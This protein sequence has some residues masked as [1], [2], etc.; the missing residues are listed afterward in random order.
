[1][2]I[3]IKF[4]RTH[5]FQV[6]THTIIKKLYSFIF[7]NHEYKHLHH[8]AFYHLHLSAKK[9]GQIKTPNTTQWS[10]QWNGTVR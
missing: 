9:Y 7:P 4:L 1:M 5:N 10:K 6:T 3:C 8:L 2:I